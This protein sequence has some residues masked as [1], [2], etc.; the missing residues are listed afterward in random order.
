MRPESHPFGWLTETVPEVGCD[1]PVQPERG[2]LSLAV[3]QDFLAR[4]LPSLSLGSPLTICPVSSHPGPGTVFVMAGPGA[5][6]QALASKEWPECWANPS[7]ASAHEAPADNPRNSHE[8]GSDMMTTQCIC[9]LHANPG[10][11][12]SPLSPIHLCPPSASRTLGGTDF[13]CGFH[14]RWALPC[15]CKRLCPHKGTWS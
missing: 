2:L 3:S 9:P 11:F 12:A 8:C 10:A 5:L 13:S 14:K 15:P 1:L 7:R 4:E 6:T